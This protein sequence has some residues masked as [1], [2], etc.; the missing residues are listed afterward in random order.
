M[1]TEAKRS[2]IS[3]IDELL[4]SFDTVLNFTF[5]HYGH[6]YVVMGR[7]LYSAAMVSSSYFFFL[8]SFRSPIRSSSRLDVYHTST[9]DV[10]LL[11]I[12]NACLKFAARGSLKKIQDSKICY[13]RTSI[14]RAISSQFATKA[15]RQSEKMFK[16][17]IST[18]YSHNM[19]NFGH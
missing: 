9:Y 6:P 17:N 19:V 12:L 13:H 2:P 10:A 11:R 1:S 8:F 18:T 5:V 3:A 7:P 16:S 4:L 14:C 15:Y